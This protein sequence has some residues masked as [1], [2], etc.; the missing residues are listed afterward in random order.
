MVILSKFAQRSMDVPET[1]IF[2]DTGGEIEYLDRAN[3]EWH[4]IKYI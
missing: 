1:L 2:F 4:V 3:L